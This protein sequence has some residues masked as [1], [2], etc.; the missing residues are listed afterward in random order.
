VP[1][2]AISVF[3]PKAFSLF[4]LEPKTLL[5]EQRA[6]V[7][8]DVRLCVSFSRNDGHG[9]LRQA[10]GHTKNVSP[11]G[12]YIEAGQI[13]PV[14]ARLHIEFELSTD[15]TTKPALRLEAQGHVLRLGLPS[16]EAESRGFAVRLQ[17]T[18]VQTR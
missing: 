1:Y 18:R 10:N 5:A 2:R 15:L 4:G 17:S 8:Y 11:K 16:G 6:A 7:R 9:D 12:A 3:E 14:G 13:P